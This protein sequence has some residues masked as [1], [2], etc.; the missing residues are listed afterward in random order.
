MLG[1]RALFGVE[2][3]GCGGVMFYGRSLGPAAMDSWA[4]KRRYTS[5]STSHS[6]RETSV[7]STT[8]SIGNISHYCRGTAGVHFL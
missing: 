6:V 4:Y 5:G 3:I 8:V 1:F 7:I 2:G